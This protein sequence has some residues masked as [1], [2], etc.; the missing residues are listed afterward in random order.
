MYDGN[1][2]ILLSS[3]CLHIVVHMYAYTDIWRRGLLYI[4]QQARNIIVVPYKIPPLKMLIQNSFHHHI[5][6]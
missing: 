6:I 3:L 2:F 5:H 1:A 4:V